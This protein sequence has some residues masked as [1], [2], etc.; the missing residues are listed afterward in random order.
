M[1]IL[2]IHGFNGTPAGPKLDML[3]NEYPA[4]TVIAPKHDSVPDHVHELLDEIAATLDEMDDIIIGNSLGGFWAN[5]FSLR[6]GVPALLINPVVSPS[7][8]LGHLG[9]PFAD[10]YL[11]FEKAIEPDGISPR[12]LLLAEDDEVIPYR[13]AFD[14]FSGNCHVKLLNS[15][16][17]GM[18][19]P[20]SIAIIKES[21]SG[22]FASALATQLND[23]D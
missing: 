17:H 5:F 18:N 22:A 1:K 2:Y 23:T 3:T 21:I 8:S 12:T 7:T 10:D 13:E 11:P 6:Y 15:G 14:S 4:A 19:D 9:C 16:G 20:Q